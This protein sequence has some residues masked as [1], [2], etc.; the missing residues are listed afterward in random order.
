MPKPS[1]NDI[2]S[3]SDSLVVGGGERVRSDQEI[4]KALLS[5][6]PPYDAHPEHYFGM[7]DVAPFECLRFQDIGIG[8]PADKPKCIVF[9]PYVGYILMVEL[10]LRMFDAS[11]TLLHYSPRYPDDPVVRH[12]SMPLSKLAGNGVPTTEEAV[13]IYNDFAD[14]HGIERRL[15]ATNPFCVL[16]ATCPDDL[17]DKLMLAMSERTSDAGVLV[18][19]R[20]LEEHWKDEMAIYLV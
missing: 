9:P 8:F 1:V 19:K 6:Y 4:K 20:L 2:L 5:G 16:I 3:I 14:R 10:S 12:T 17:P 15:S 13:A 7:Q 18:T 11:Y